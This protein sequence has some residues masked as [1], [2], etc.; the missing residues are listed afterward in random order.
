MTLKHKNII[1]LDGY[2]EDY[3]Y[4][5]LIMEYAPHGDLNQ[6][7]EKQK[8]LSELETARHI[9]SLIKALLYCHEH[10][11]LHRDVKPENLLISS[12]GDLLLADFGYWQ[13]IPFS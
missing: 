9:E 11:Y 13:S 1:G 5:Y 10:S 7:L 2:F 12:K 8:R 4:V 3:K 6:L